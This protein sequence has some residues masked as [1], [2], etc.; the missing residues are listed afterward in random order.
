MGEVPADPVTAR[1]VTEG[2]EVPATVVEL[3]YA[4]S[5]PVEPEGIEPLPPL[6]PTEMAVFELLQ[7]IF[8]EPPESLNPLETLLASKL[9]V[10]M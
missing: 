6:H 2:V 5:C 8:V 3:V 1:V 9:L 10:R 7:M 4:R